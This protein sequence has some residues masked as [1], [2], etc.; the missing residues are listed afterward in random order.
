ME[1]ISRERVIA[2][3]NHIEPDRVPIDVAP[4]YDFYINLKSYLGLEINEEV[5]YDFQWKLFPIPMC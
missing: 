5:R 1:W 3:I 4:L 2:A